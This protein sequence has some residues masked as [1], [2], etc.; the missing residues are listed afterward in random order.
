VG[1]W[2]ADGSVARGINDEVSAKAT[3]SSRLDVIFNKFDSSIGKDSGKLTVFDKP[4]VSTNKSVVRTSP[5]GENSVEEVGDNPT[6]SD[7]G[8]SAATGGR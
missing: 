6:N 8:E 7:V 2:D 3:V 4:D 1:D 5:L